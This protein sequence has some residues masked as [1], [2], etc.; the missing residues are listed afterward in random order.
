MDFKSLSKKAKY[1]WIITSVVLAII[2]MTTIVAM[3]L[4]VDKNLTLVLALSVGLPCLMLS[5][6]IVVYAFL[7]YH[8]YKY[9]YNEEK[10][11][12]RYGVIFKHTV[13]IPICQIQ[14]L[15]IYEGPIMTLLKLKGVILSTAGSNFEIKCL[16]SSVAQNLVDDVEIFL[17]KRLEV[18][19][20]EKVW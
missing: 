10:I 20:N 1:Y 19:S 3:I 15:H 13:V 11:I 7:K 18:L 8:F 2:I 12:I 9:A 4:L 14:D 5:I 6:F 16:E 17:K